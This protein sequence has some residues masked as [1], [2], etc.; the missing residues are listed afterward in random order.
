MQQAVVDLA[1]LGNGLGAPAFLLVLATALWKVGRH[2]EALGTL[3]LG[4]AQAEM[5]SQ[6]YVDGEPHRLRGEILA[7]RRQVADLL[8]LLGERS[9][10]S[11]S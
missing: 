2:D 7:M 11:S 3:D 6:H 4:F 8:K 1:G 5:T 10:T 9:A